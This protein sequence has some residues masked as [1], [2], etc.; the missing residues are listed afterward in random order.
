MKI[1]FGT[2]K[3]FDKEN[4][5]YDGEVFITEKLP[6][7]LQEK[8]EKHSEA[9]SNNLKKTTKPFFFITVAIVLTICATVMRLVAKVVGGITESIDPELYL[10]VA[11]IIIFV[12][13]CVIIAANV[14]K[15]DRTLKGDTAQRLKE[16]GDII[17]KECLEAMRVPLEAIDVDFLTMDYQYQ[18][19]ELVIVETMGCKFINIEYKTYA[20]EGVLCIADVEQ[21]HTISLS[22]IVSI[23]RIDEKISFS[24]WNKE[25]LHNQGEFEQ[26]KIKYN[27]KQYYYTVKW[28][29]SLVIN[30][31][32][33]EYE[34]Y[35][36]PYELDTI[37]KLTG[38]KA[39]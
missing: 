20:E 6:S 2:D 4:E 8:F 16:Q 31:S 23:K 39:E 30:H 38:L 11:A 5:K 3:T 25:T 13:V 26:Y 33:E 18:N 22:E 29:Y 12:G 24:F 36:P 34:L 17:S 1:F 19:G 14:V 35:F 7:D 10:G 28:Y 21:K 9:V 27:K 15:I 37:E 32:G